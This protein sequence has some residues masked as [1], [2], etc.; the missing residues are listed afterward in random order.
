MR[1]IKK[2]E[3]A[4]LTW[5]QRVRRS[6]RQVMPLIELILPVPVLFL[7]AAVRPVIPHD[8]AS[9][10]VLARATDQALDREGSRRRTSRELRFRSRRLQ[11]VAR[12]SDVELGLL[13]TRIHNLDLR[14]GTDGSRKSRAEPR[15]RLND[16]YVAWSF[17]FTCGNCRSSRDSKRRFRPLA[18][19]CLEYFRKLNRADLIVLCAESEWDLQ[20]MSAAINFI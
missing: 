6:G 20:P 5:G 7:L 19:F 9:I 18:N 12:R 16:T 8:T 11:L 4:R 17:L 14:D 3:R 2:E 10:V 13:H 15:S 1:G